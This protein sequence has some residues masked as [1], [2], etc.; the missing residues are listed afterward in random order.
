MD[1][2]TIL[3]GMG[4]T[5]AGLFAAG[6]GAGSVDV[7][8][9]W[10]PSPQ[11]DANGNPLAPALY[12]EVFVTRDARPESLAA[13]VDDTFWQTTAEPGSRYCVRVRGVDAWDRR[14]PMSPPSAWWIVPGLSAV[15]ADPRPFLGPAVPN[16]FNP[17]T[18]IRYTIPSGSGGS[19]TMRIMDARGRL[20]RELEIGTAPGPHSVVWDGTDGRGSPLG[21]GIYLVHLRCGAA[22]VTTKVTL[23]K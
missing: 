19:P 2:K 21:T 22:T 1:A 14:G 10:N 20:V 8:W 11:T 3:L 13:A 18:T 4:L 16:P 17:V 12:Y 23:M 9:Q 5:L 7:T 15:P 6:D